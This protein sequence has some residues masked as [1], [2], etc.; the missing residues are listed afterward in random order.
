MLC[1]FEGVLVSGSK[2]RTIR[3]WSLMKGKAVK[4]LKLK[5]KTLKSD[6]IAVYVW[7]VN[8]LTDN[9]LVEGKRNTDDSSRIYVALHWPD[10]SDTSFLSSSFYGDLLLWDLSKPD[11]EMCQ[12]S[13]KRL[14]SHIIFYILFTSIFQ[15]NYILVISTFHPKN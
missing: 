11:K 15:F 12:V 3:V 14:R 4:I 6:N 2:D 8:V 7:F 10:N 9:L 1:R 13:I 5:S